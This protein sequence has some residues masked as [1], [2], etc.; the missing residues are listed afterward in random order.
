[1]QSKEEIFS[2]LKVILVDLFEIEESH[3][4]PDAN[5]YEDLDL[6]SIDAIDLVVKLQQL[7]K[8]RVEPEAFKN[9]RK[10]QDVVDVIYNLVRQ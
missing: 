2:E 4:T 8:K 7:T 1:M 10:I 6:D 5:L 3:I 9:V